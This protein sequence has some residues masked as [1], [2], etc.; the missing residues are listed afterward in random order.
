MGSK[1]VSHFVLADRAVAVNV[2]HQHLG[3]SL[4]TATT[5][6]ECDQELLGL[7]VGQL[8]RAAQCEVAPH[9]VDHLAVRV[10][11]VLGWLACDGLDLEAAADLEGLALVDGLQDDVALLIRLNP[12]CLLLSQIAALDA[13]VGGAVDVHSDVLDGLG[14]VVEHDAGTFLVGDLLVCDTRL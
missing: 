7:R 12:N 9:A 3:L 10:V 14:L 13:D 4:V 6:R 11:D 1:E 5:V 2:D 8:S